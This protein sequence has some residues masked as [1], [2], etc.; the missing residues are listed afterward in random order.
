MDG[1]FHGKSMKQMD[2]LG[3]QFP[4]NWTPPYHQKPLEMT[5][6][7]IGSPGW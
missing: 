6:A 7:A 5:P 2:D 1:L 4:M 3:V